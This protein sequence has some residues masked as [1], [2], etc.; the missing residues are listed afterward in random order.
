[1]IDEAIPRG[2]QTRSAIIQAAHDL[3]IQQ[4]FHGT[5]MRQIARRAGVALGSMYNHFTSKEEVFRT[6]FLAYHPYHEVLPALLTVQGNSI[7]ERVRDAA[8]R[9]LQAVAQRPDFLNLMFIELVEFKSSHAQELLD[10]LFPN[11]IQVVQNIIQGEPQRLRTIPTPILIRSFLGLFFAYYLTEL[12]FT[13]WAPT[14]FRTD[15]IDHMT[16]IYLHGIL[17]EHPASITS[18]NPHG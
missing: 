16:S 18:R 3:F 12:V 11:A 5:S 17:A 1:M 13:S 9:M 6:V 2:E 14:E 15:A 10:T 8:N 4:G 7:E